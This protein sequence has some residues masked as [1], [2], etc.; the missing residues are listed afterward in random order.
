MKFI[1]G[2][3][4]YQDWRD[5]S[6]DNNKT[7][8]RK[9][10]IRA[11][12][13]KEDLTIADQFQLVQAINVSELSGKLEGFYSISTSVLMNKICQARARMEGSICADCYA[14]NNVARYSQLTQALEC[15]H[16]ILN[17]FL[18]DT[19]CWKAL[20]LPST[21]GKFRIES[22]GDVE[23]VTCARNY[24][25][26]IDA[27]KHLFFGVWTKNTEIWLKAFQLEGHKPENM[28]FIVSSPYKNAV[29]GITLDI[30][31]YVDHVFTVYDPEFV[32]AHNVAINCGIR[33]CKD[34]MRCYNASNREYQISELLK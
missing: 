14:A 26:I 23:T 10:I 30:A 17:R 7:I 24:I 19:E 8:A 31:P 13:N 27:H 1:N 4:N 28:K 33:K 32:K 3:T 16:I 29:L 18:I 25:R 12:E 22:H 5:V 20:A 11:M 34:C 2:I 6:K 9:V 21:N 15:N